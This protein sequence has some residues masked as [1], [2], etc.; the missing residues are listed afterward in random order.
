MFISM[1]DDGYYS[2]GVMTQLEGVGI[3]DLVANNM[4]SKPATAAN[5]AHLWLKLAKASTPPL[6]PQPTCQTF[7]RLTSHQR[8]CLSTTSASI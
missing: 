8:S 1:F 7:F 5:N 4:Y 3:G 6:K 2:D